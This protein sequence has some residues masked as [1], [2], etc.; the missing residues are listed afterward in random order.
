MVKVTA[1]T[2]VLSS[3]TQECP[4]FLLSPKTQILSK[5]P[6]IPEYC[7]FS[8]EICCF[9]AVDVCFPSGGWFSGWSQE[10]ELTI[11]RCARAV[12]KR[13]RWHRGLTNAVRDCSAL[14]FPC[15]MSHNHST[16]ERAV[17]SWFGCPAQV[18]VQKSEVRA[19]AVASAFGCNPR[20]RCCCCE[21]TGKAIARRAMLEGRGTQCV[22]IGKWST[23]TQTI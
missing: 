13:P 14:Q 4:R 16:S 11:G 10:S 18:F 17:F 21:G 7:R 22:Q 20:R 15:L 8:I 5:T 19:S 1:V 23:Q 6:K 3:Q 12:Q 9:C 2:A